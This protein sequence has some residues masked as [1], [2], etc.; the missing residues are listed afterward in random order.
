[1]T[2]V[3]AQYWAYIAQFLS[4][5]QEIIYLSVTFTTCKECIHSSQYNK[6]MFLIKKFSLLIYDL[7]SEDWINTYYML[8]GFLKARR[9]PKV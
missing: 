7:Q 1:M 4:Q 9:P 6:P 8:K 5:I 2:V 3:L